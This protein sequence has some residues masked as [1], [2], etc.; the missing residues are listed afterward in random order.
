MCDDA[1]R[2]S[3]RRVCAASPASPPVFP[4]GRLHLHTRHRIVP[5]A[6][7]CEGA[8]N[9][10]N[11][12]KKKKEEA[13]HVHTGVARSMSGGCVRWLVRGASR[14][15]CRLGTSAR[16]TE[17]RLFLPF[18]PALP[19]LARP[20]PLAAGFVVY[21]KVSH[22]FLLFSC[23]AAVASTYYLFCLSLPFPLPPSLP[24]RCFLS[25]LLCFGPLLP[26]LALRH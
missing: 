5:A 16:P 17:P 15:S 3:S 19:L 10:N 11:S 12:G 14:R 24:P 23:C 25:F 20:S 8:N 18:H 6:G 22:V 26:L 4:C 13:T 7:S 9:N 21:A 1:C 2:F